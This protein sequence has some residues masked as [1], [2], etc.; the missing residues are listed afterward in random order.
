MRSRRNLIHQY[1]LSVFVRLLEHKH[2]DR[3][4]PHDF[5]F[6]RKPPRDMLGLFRNRRNRNGSIPSER[7]RLE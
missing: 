7:T 2:L 6:F 4:Q 5:K 3:Q 1:T